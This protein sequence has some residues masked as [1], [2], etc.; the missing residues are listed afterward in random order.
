MVGCGSKICP[1]HTVTPLRMRR[2]LQAV[3]L[4]CSP[5]S[6]LHQFV[7][8]SGAR[9][10]ERSGGSFGALRSPAAID[11]QAGSNE[12]GFHK[13]LLSLTSVIALRSFAR[14]YIWHVQGRHTAPQNDKGSR[15]SFRVPFPGLFVGLS[16][17]RGNGYHRLRTSKLT[18]RP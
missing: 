6:L 15:G 16:E 2:I 14:C 9:F 8:W 5:E 3:E 17:D 7:K 13:I 10:P 12:Q 18:I 1:Q 11:Q 4:P